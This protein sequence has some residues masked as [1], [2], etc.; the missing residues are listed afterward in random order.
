VVGP[1]YRPA[2]VGEKKGAIHVFF[3][4]SV[5]SPFYYETVP[6]EKKVLEGIGSGYKWTW[7]CFYVFGL[8]KNQRLLR[9][10]GK[11]MHQTKEQFAETKQ[12]ARLF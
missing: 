7:K 2:L 4:N 3:F 6:R 9:I 1:C 12:P 10:L 5:A 8:S 11:E